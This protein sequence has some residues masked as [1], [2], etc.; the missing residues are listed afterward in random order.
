M[1]PD[2]PVRSC[3][4]LEKRVSSLLAPTLKLKQTTSC[5]Y[6]ALLLRIV[7]SASQPSFT[8]PPVMAH[9]TGA[10]SSYLRCYQYGNLGRSVI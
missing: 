6:F 7:R 10:A 5:A 1:K 4:N 9:L 8:K 2:S 3:S